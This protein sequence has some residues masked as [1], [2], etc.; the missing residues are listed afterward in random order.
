M[1]WCVCERGQRLELAMC[2]QRESTAYSW[3]R[4]R[5]PTEDVQD[6]IYVVVHTFASL[7]ES[8]ISQLEIHKCVFVIGR[9]IA[10]LHHLIAELN[11]GKGRRK[12]IKQQ[13][14]KNKQKKRTLRS[15]N[16]PFWRRHS[17]GTV[18]SLR[19]FANFAKS[20]TVLTLRKEV[21]SFVMPRLV[22]F[23]F[24]CFLINLSCSKC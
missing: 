11:C 16:L 2:G 5:T 20:I 3:V 22:L 21:V 7:P 14:N 18:F 12:K 8:S 13:K 1:C 6:L 19:S 4:R 24:H 10:C 23:E 15:G 9:L 17:P